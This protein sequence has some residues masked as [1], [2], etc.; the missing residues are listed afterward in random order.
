MVFVAVDEAMRFVNDA[1][2]N[3]TPQS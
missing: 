3:K 2:L 1:W